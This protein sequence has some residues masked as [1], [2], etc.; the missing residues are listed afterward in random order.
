MSIPS[1]CSPIGPYVHIS[2]NI[3]IYSCSCRQPWTR[4]KGSLLLV[5]R[6]QRGVES[7]LIFAQHLIHGKFIFKLYI[8][9]EKLYALVQIYIVKWCILYRTIL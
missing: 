4:W 1:A 3:I 7:P 8:D 6:L 5:C 9:P 2:P